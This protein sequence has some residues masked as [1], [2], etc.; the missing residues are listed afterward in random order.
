[1]GDCNRVTGRFV[2]R[3]AEELLESDIAHLV[4]I[5]ADAGEHCDWTQEK[6]LEELF[7]T[8]RVGVLGWNY[9]VPST[10][11][12]EAVEMSAA[13]MNT[14]WRTWTKDCISE[15]NK[16]ARA[17]DP[18]HY[19]KLPTAE[20][21]VGAQVFLKLWP[22]RIF[23]YFSAVCSS[24]RFVPIENVTLPANTSTWSVLYQS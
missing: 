15:K 21:Q 19:I 12:P 10:G 6:L 16:N 8:T 18:Y 13:D 11:V 4:D 20:R 2:V 22:S 7:A 9:A 24:S 5:V 17:L 14:M 3:A 1:M 23:S